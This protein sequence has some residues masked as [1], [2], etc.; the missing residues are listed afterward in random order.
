MKE[1]MTCDAISALVRVTCREYT[2]FDRQPQNSYIRT[3][4]DKLFFITGGTGLVGSNLIPRILLNDPGSTIILLVRGENDEEV[5]ERTKSIAGRIAQ[6]FALPDAHERIEGL[7]GDVSL[8]SFGLAPEQL[9]RIVRASTHIIHGAA[10]IRFDH[11]IHEARAINCGGTARILAIAQQCA[12]RGQLERFVYIGTSSVS[13]QREGNIYEHELEMGQ[14]FFNTYEQSK[15]ESERLVRDHFDRIP[16][17]VFRPSIIIGNSR[18]GRTTSFNVVYI[19]L[20]LLQRGLLHFVPGDPDTT[21]DLVPIDWVDDV[22]VH[23]TGK[24]ASVGNICHVTAGPGRAARL[25]DVVEFA[26]RYFDEHTPLKQPRTVDFITRAEFLRRRA[27]TRGRE[28]A[29]LAQLDTLLPYVSVNRLF[30]S[31]NTDR[32][33]EGSGIKFPMFG[34]YADRILRYCVETNWGK[35]ADPSDPAHMTSLPSR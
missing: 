4:M 31:Q 30:N 7:R 29:L 21:L 13:G 32:L 16:S 23:I 10:T 9:R 3:L 1:Q 2:N 35:N 18:T 14:A 17:T 28:E 8:D 12:D 33:L 34:S 26:I 6:E 27:A 15:C 11:P 22:L 25:G 24:T 19:P 20:R 5:V